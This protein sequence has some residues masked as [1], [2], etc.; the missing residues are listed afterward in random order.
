[1]VRTLVFFSS[2]WVVKNHVYTPK[3][4]LLGCAF[5]GEHGK[6]AVNGHQ[7]G[8]LQV[9]AMFTCPFWHRISGVSVCPVPVCPLV[10]SWQVRVLTDRTVATVLSTDGVHTTTAEGLQLVESL[11]VEARSIIRVISA[12][13]SQSAALAGGL[14]NR[15]QIWLIF[16][17]RGDDFF[18]G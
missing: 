1:M 6:G 15:F 11:A 12:G 9:D 3:F 13:S 5:A 7:T 18:D 14:T 4:T 8:L 10:V 16:S 17:R 2:R